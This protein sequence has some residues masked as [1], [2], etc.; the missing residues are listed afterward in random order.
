MKV[1][2]CGSRSFT[3]PF[4]VSLAIDQRIS[5]LPRGTCVLSGHARGADAMAEE[6]ATR[7]D[8]NVLLFPADWE[9]HGKKAGVLRNLT[10][11][12]QQ[13][14]LVIAFWDGESRGTQHTITEARKRGIPVEV[15]AASVP[16][17]PPASTGETR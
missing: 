11:L 2:V 1:L 17:V 16:A 3:D 13:P 8:H 5:E 7:Y 12:D 10:M 6:A 15:I 14:D 4:R 9:T